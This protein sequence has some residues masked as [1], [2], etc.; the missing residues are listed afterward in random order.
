MKK[1]V[2]ILLVA[3]MTLSI[4]SGCGKSIEEMNEVASKMFKA[5][6]SALSEME[7]EEMDLGGVHGFTI[8]SNGQLCGDTGEFEKDIFIEKISKFFEDNDK[9]YWLVYIR[10][11]SA[12]EVYAAEKKDSK[13]IGAYP[14]S[15]D[16]ADK[17]IDDIQEELKSKDTF[18]ITVDDFVEQFNEKANDFYE[19]T[20]LDFTLNKVDDNIYTYA[21]SV[22]LT[23]HEKGGYIFNF[24]VVV[25]VTDYYDL[26]SITQQSCVYV[27]LAPA[28]VVDTEKDLYELSETLYSDYNFS[29]DNVY[30]MFTEPFSV[31][32][33]PLLVIRTNNN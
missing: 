22:K 7:D 6:N 8:D 18:G 32:T 4:F 11:G 9:Y 12:I 31:I 15:I 10:S 33:E 19:K 5:A 28:L 14:D 29:D 16:T 23:I 20:N 13:I 1:T 30:Y 3:I 21:N 2:L 27:M 17:T 26:D 25:Q 24:N